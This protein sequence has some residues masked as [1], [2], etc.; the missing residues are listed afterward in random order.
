MENSSQWWVQK[1]IDA[2]QFVDFTDNGKN[3]DFSQKEAAMTLSLSLRAWKIEEVIDM[4]WC[5]LSAA[6]MPKIYEM[7]KCDVECNVE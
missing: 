4:C 1:V 7:I 6:K 5:T 2:S 3:R